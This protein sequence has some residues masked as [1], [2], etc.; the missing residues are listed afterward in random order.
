VEL[1]AGRVYSTD[2]LSYQLR[3]KGYRVTRPR[4]AVWRALNDAQGHLTVE[5]L[6]GR[7]AQRHPGVNLASVYR[8][9]ALFAQLDLVRES[10]LGDTDVTRWEIAHPDEHF[11][12]VCDVCGRVDHH[13]GDLVARVV[14]HL[15]S[16]HRFEPRSVELT[17]AGRCADCTDELAGV[18]TG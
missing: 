11:H 13:A 9:L 16:R 1:Y 6:A 17:V 15:R 3:L 8:S 2:E 14:D 7:V 12:L 10:R 18:A 4:Q 5:E